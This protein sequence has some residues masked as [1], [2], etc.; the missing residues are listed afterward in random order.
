[1][2]PGESYKA[3]LDLEGKVFIPMHYGTF[4]LSDE[5]PGEPIRI[6]RK[7]FEQANSGTKFKELAVGESFFLA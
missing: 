3:F 4:D 6:I 2:D 5:P 7:L 1:M